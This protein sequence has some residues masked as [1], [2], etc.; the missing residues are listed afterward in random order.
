[1]SLSNDAFVDIVGDE[2]SFQFCI[3][4]AFTSP[5]QQTL[6]QNHRALHNCYK[7][8]NMMKFLAFKWLLNELLFE[9]EWSE[10]KL[11]WSFVSIKFIKY[12]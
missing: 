7:V 3:E 11:V 5:L 6:K 2:G 10:V 9:K 12:F 8:K 4:T 1:M